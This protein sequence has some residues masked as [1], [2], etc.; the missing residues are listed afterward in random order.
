MAKFCLIA[1]AILITNMYV[2]TMDPQNEMDLE[3]EKYH[4][5]AELESNL[6]RLFNQFPSNGEP[7]LKISF[8]NAQI[9]YLLF[10]K[11]SMNEARKEA[12]KTEVDHN[13]ARLLRIPVTRDQTNQLAERNSQIFE[14]LDQLDK[15]ISQIYAI[16]P[17]R[18]IFHLTKERDANNVRLQRAGT[19]PSGFNRRLLSIR[20]Y[21]IEHLLNT[22]RSM[23]QAS[24]KKLLDEMKGN[25]DSYYTYFAV[26]PKEKRLLD[27]RNKEISEKIEELKAV[28]DLM[29]ISNDVLANQP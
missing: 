25:L 27:K 14:R 11:P 19:D 21:E 2:Y 18:E 5:K 6:G 13:L 20:N 29:R 3:T 23:D 26:T 12:L 28:A 9:G 22:Q 15:E 4:L 1:A 7:R 8:R 16:T 10:E 24:R 17:Q